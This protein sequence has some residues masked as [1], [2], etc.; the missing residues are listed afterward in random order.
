MKDLEGQI[1]RLR[2][3]VADL[4]EE[5]KQTKVELVA[6]KVETVALRLEEQ[7]LQ[8]RIDILNSKIAPI[9]KL[10]WG[11][12]SAIVIGLISGLLLVNRT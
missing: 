5:V 8:T 1:E 4:R 10:L 11:I 7:K 12:I 3:V 6:V 2:E 9:L